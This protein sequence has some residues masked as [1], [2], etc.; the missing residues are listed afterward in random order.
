MENPGTHRVTTVADRRHRVAAR[1]LQGEYQSAIA[2]ELGVSQAQVSLDLKAM[3]ALWLQSAMRDFDTL[4]SEQLAKIDRVEVAAWEAYAR[5]LLPREITVTEQSE[6]GEAVDE[7]GTKRP[8]S[9]TRKASMRREGQAGDPRFLE[10]VQKSIDQRSALLGLEAPKRIKI[11][12]DALT[13]EQM[14]RLANGERPDL[15]LAAPKPE[16]PA[17]MA[18]A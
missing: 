5:S 1:Y 18:E 2:R 10:R 13:D 7:D 15:V 11:D 9:P 12:W 16:P 17:S 8:K 14:L 4:V 6:G 3:R